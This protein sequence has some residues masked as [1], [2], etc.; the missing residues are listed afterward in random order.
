MKTYA[1]AVIGGGTVAEPHLQAYARLD[2]VRLI[3]LVEPRTGRREELAQRYGVPGYAS[4]A[5]LLQRVRLDV[6][7]VLTPVAT[8]R[9][10]TEQCA[11]AGVHVLCEKPMAVTLEDARAMAAACRAAKVSFFYGSSYR[12]LPAVVEAR[13]RISAGEIGAIR[14]ILEQVLGGDGAAAYR[15]MSTEHY[16]QGGPG[17]GGYGLVDH[18]I[19]MLDVFPWLCGSP[20]NAVF[21]RGD[22]SGAPARPELA[23][24]GLACGAQGV[25]IYDQSSR[26]LD[27]P[28][29][30]TFS[31]ARSWIESRGWTG[32]SGAW[33][34]HPGQIRVFGSTGALRI[35]HYANR[36]FVNR[37]GQMEALQLPDTTTP[38]HFG[39]QLRR[40]CE[41]IERGE[42][43][44]SS[45]DDGIRALQALLAIYESEQ[46]GAWR[47]VPTG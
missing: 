11:A 23:W 9:M 41:N 25:L 44:A 12:F 19:H 47:S 3:G 26:W 34:A 40:F 29:E 30:G 37:S 21:G 1:V 13:R 18:G 7:C 22:R 28:A 2:C 16:P 17:G 31:G 5:E 43:P 38:W 42:E 15:A 6:A 24:V 20:I 32:D 8:H 4:C 39:A 46:T 45:A 35:F 27:L 14:L 33:D 36:L 10:I